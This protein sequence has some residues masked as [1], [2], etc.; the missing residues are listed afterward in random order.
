MK[1]IFFLFFLVLLTISFVSAGLELG[2]DD[3]DIPKV[4]IT[5][6]SVVTPATG[7]ITDTSAAVNCS[8]DEVFLGNGSCQS[9]STITG[10][11]DGSYNVTYDTYILINQSN[12]T[13]WWAGIN[14]WVSGWFVNVGD[15]LS[16]NG[17]KLNETIDARSISGSYNDSYDA[18]SNGTFNSTY[19][20]YVTLNSTNSSNY[21]DDADTW[22]ATQMEN[23]DGTLTILMSWLK[24]LFYEKSEVYNK[25]ETYNKT[26]VYNKSETDNNLSLK[27]SKSGDTMT[28]NLT[29]SD[30]SA[31]ITDS[32]KDVSMYFEN[33]YMVVEG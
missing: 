17:T 22:N 26:E 33:G 1:Y 18:I 13:T 5:R 20:T 28:G 14:G 29:L 3:E 23:N 31:R 12:S 6:P 19:D 32:S 9:I 11:G 16:F 8:A 30:S 4:I 7:N 10:T 25:T 24:S 15:E 2:F 21:W 27:V